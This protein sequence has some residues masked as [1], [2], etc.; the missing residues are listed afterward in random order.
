MHGMK[1]TV[2]T[3]KSAVCF[4]LM[5]ALAAVFVLPL[6]AQTL[7]YGQYSGTALAAIP[8]GNDYDTALNPGNIG[9]LKDVFLSHDLVMKLSG[10][11][12]QAALEVWFSIGQQTGFSPADLGLSDEE[13]PLYTIDLQRA[14][15]S[16]YMGDEI[17]I[18]LGRHSL[19][20]GYGYGWNPMDFANPPKDPSDPSAELTGVDSL[21]VHLFPFGTVNLKLYGLVDSASGVDYK[22]LQAGGELTMALPFAEL[23][24]TGLFDRDETGGEDDKVSAMGAGFLADIAG[25][26]LYGEAAVFDGSRTGFPDGVSMPVIKDEVLFSGLAGLEY[27]FL[28]ELT[29]VAEYFYNGEGFDKSERDEYLATLENPAVLG[30]A[31]IFAAFAGLYRP[32]YFS[33]HYGLLNLLYPLYDL[34]LDLSGMVLFAADSGALTVLPMI[35]WYTTGSLTL[36]MSYS[37]LFSLY[38]EDSDEASLSPYKHAVSLAG[39]FSF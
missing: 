18:K 3:R 29:L 13:T 38:G 30:D 31:A 22:N 17:R 6:G 1:N 2:K 20:T 7:F 32:G 16:W 36:E 23:K 12:E 21:L 26:G 9:G 15:I 39:K 34:N 8:G 27:T 35:T 25:A 5:I 28:N 11:D 19:L 14:G 24:F 4:A 37:G 33:R 10:G